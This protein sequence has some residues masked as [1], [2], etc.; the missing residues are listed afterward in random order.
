MD[1][2]KN[3][4]DVLYTLV[5]VGVPVIATIIGIWLGKWLERKEKRLDK[6]ISAYMSAEK[7]LSKWMKDIM[8]LSDTP[9][10]KIADELEEAKAL[11]VLV[12]SKKAIDAFAIIQQAILEIENE[13]SEKRAKGELKP[14]KGGTRQL[15]NYAKFMDAKTNW[16]NIVRKEIGTD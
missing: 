13:M 9:L 12:G 7:V 15:R 8:V 2:S 6:K 11:M 1:N 10:L 3:I 5:I 14:P 4:Y 16:I